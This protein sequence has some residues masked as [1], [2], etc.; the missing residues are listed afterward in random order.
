VLELNPE[1]MQIVWEWHLADHL[2]QD[3]DR[4]KANYGDVAQHP[5]LFDFNFAVK[6]PDFTTTYDIPVDWIHANS[7]TYNPKLDQILISAHEPSEFW[8]IDHS[9]TTAEAA[10]HSGGKYKKGGDL[11]YR[12]GNPAAYRAGDA[13]D[14]V[15]WFQHDA[16][17]IPDGLPGAGNITL[18]DNGSYVGR[19]TSRALELSLGANADGSYTLEPGKV[20]P[21]KIVWEYV[22]DETNFSFIMGS[23][24]RLPNGNTLV[25]D[26]F[27]STMNEVTATNKVVWK[28][29]DPAQR[30][31]FHVDRYALDYPAFAGKVLT[32][33]PEQI[34]YATQ[35]PAL[36]GTTVPTP[37]TATT[38]P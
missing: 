1:T 14:Q 25:T 35:G 30:Y 13:A 36:V 16:R 22:I 11:L 5:E 24:Q 20:A 37:A 12:W 4:T 23:V 18:F 19:A 31:L 26:S 15:F 9:T 21:V 33:L 28:Y 32:R 34:P 8:I 3:Y 38:A 2:V 29:S 27:K 7:V 10:S 6:F 17:W